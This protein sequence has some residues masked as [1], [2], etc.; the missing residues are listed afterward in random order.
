MRCFKGKYAP[1]A[2][3]KY[4]LT[5]VIKFSNMLNDEYPTDQSIEH[6]TLTDILNINTAL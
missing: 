6:L 5:P 1:S 3:K 4:R 2:V